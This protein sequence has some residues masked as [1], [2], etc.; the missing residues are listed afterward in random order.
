MTTTLTHL[1]TGDTQDVEMVLDYR[2]TRRVG[3][4]AH[5]IVGRA[6]VDFT[7]KPAGPR[8][9]TYRLFA[10]DELDAALVFAFV[11]REGAFTLVDTETAMADA[12][13]TPTGDITFELD[14]TTKRA[15][16]VAVDYTEVLT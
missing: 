10:M 7:L 3:T 9:G 11:A 14:D 1:P 5:E 13:F 4:V 12:T 6:A 8:T 15:V 16:V 2:A